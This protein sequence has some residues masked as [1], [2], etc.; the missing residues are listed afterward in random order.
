MG[1]RRLAAIVAA[2]VVGFSSLM[3]ADED[4]TL[5]TLKAHRTATD[6]IVLNHG[7]RVVKN[8]GDGMLLEV[9]S[10]VEAVRAAIEVQQTMA[11][12][13]AE[14]SPERRMQYRIGINL[15]DIIIDDDQDVYGDGV[16]VAARLEPLADPGGICIS[17]AV[18]RHVAD[19]L[20]DVQFVDRGQHVLKNI[21][22]PVQ[23][24]AVRTS[25]D[26]GDAPIVRPFSPSTAVAVL[27]FVN[28][29]ADADQEYFADGITEDLITA[30]S[31]DPYLHV[32]A[33]NSVFA[34]KGEPVDVRTVGRRLD[35]RYVVEGSVRRSA[36]RVRVSAQL[37]ES[38]SG[39]HLWAD[40]YDRDLGD[41]F[42][43]QD[44]IVDEV[45]LRVAP[46]VRSAEERRVA[47]GRPERLDAWEL[48]QRGRWH[49]NRHTREGFEA[50][51]ALCERSVAMSASTLGHADLNTYWLVMGMQ[52]WHLDGRNAFDEMV[53]HGEAAYH[54]DPQASHSNA[55]IAVA[56]TFLGRTEEA[57]DFARRAVE[58]NPHVP[59]SW[60]TLGHALYFEGQHAESV[61]AATEA[62]RLGLHETWRWH[63]ATVLAFAHY[64]KHNYEAAL[65]WGDE[66]LKLND[67]LQA[68]VV[69]AAALGQQGRTEMARD[70]LAHLLDER[71]TLTV[72]DYRRGFRWREQADID[73]FLEGLAAAGLPG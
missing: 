40:R 41:V 56:R 3:S 43:L 51:I 35:A 15:G 17:D 66:A 49:A 22:A 18:H 58:L 65:R 13:N 52:R 61:Q 55:A 7:G 45:R 12:R 57:V 2:D 73:H 47:V 71:P 53:E 28:L 59:G 68:H 25:D 14:L 21:P 44:E 24:W 64:L 39:H 60:A 27:P 50:A 9:P 1:T 20:K 67:Y 37:V 63:T 70:H 8:T 26:V 46:T 4:G 29:S 54:L 30:L 33:R 32:I 6:P 5:A 23:V 38:E 36:G 16:N 11:R 42:A 48:L 62:W 10:A 31:Q 34:F 69:T 72:D 19:Q